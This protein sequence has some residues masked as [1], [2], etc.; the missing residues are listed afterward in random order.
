MLSNFLDWVA[1]LIG[2]GGGGGGDA[3]TDSVV[4]ALGALVE[5]ASNIIFLVLP[6]GIAIMGVAFVPKLIKRVMHTFF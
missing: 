5:D 1:G 4:G 2:G 3:I 6:F